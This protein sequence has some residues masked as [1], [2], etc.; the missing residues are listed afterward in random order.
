MSDSPTPTRSLRKRV[1]VILVVLLLAWLV[2]AYL[3]MPGL[4]RRYVRRHPALEDVPRVTHTKDGIPGDPLNVALIGTQA[5][6]MKIMVVW[7]SP[8]T[9][10][11]DA[12]T[13][14]L[15]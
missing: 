8:R 14:R 1:L 9:A 15:P 2:I 7:K 13:K 11:C 10:F 3:F 12:P 4:W 5:E 6:V